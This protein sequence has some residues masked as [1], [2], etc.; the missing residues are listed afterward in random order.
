M[1]MFNKRH[2]QAIALSMQ[3]AI[4]GSNGSAEVG[5]MWRVASELARTFELDNRLFKRDLFL[6][7]CEPG[8]NVRQKTV[9]AKAPP[10]ILV[11]Y[12]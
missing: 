7:A 11:E 6:Q 4:E 1:P 8:Q 12:K 5:A 10:F 3:H 9:K 2:Y